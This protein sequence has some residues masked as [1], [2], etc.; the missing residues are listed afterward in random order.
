MEFFGFA[1]GAVGAVFLARSVYSRL[2]QWHRS[3]RLRGAKAC[4]DAVHNTL[5]SIAKSRPNMGSRR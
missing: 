4:L 5:D 2:Q 1:V 3:H